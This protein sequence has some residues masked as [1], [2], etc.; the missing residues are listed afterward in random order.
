MPYGKFRFMQRGKSLHA[1]S[2]TWPRRVKRGGGQATIYRTVN[3]G[4]TLYQVGYWAGATFE[5]KSFATYTDAYSHAEQQATLQHTG[6]H[7]VAR[8]KD[9]DRDSFVAAERLVKELQTPLLEAVKAWHAATKALKGTGSLLEA[10]KEYAARHRDEMPKKTVEAVVAEF[11]ETKE[12]DKASYRYLKTLRSTLSPTP[13]TG[14]R[15]NSFADSFKT[16]IGGITAKEIDTWLRQ[17]G[18]S[19]RTRKNLLLIIRTLFNFAKS[20]GYLP[21]NQ[22]TEA[23]IVITPK[24]SGGDIG[25]F[26]PK[27]LGAMFAGTQKHAVNDEYKLWLA[28]GA[29]TGL[30]TEE[31]KRLDWG[32]VSPSRGYVEVRARKSK[33]GSRRLVPIQPNL[34]SWLAHFGKASGPVFP[35][36]RA[37]ERVHEYAKRL[38]IEWPNNALRHSY[39]TYRLAVTADMARVAIEMGNSAAMIVKHYREL[40]TEAEGKAWFAIMPPA[41]PSNVIKMK[42]A[43]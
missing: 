39:A 10:A 41:S 6:Q 13:P 19:P 28:L 2:E 30:R 43:A 23:E 31:L 3:R 22:P 36:A 25:I 27:Q 32:E 26:T 38:G 9:T 14:K 21:K 11:L 24:V 17:R 5:R 20:R 15:R 7:S 16:Y 29:F 4:R 42:G 37:E 1:N 35:R 8:M 34:A 12:Q 40:A 33:T 18:V